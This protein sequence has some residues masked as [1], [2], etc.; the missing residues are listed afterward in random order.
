MRLHKLGLSNKAEQLM[1]NM[2]GGGSI[3]ANFGTVEEGSF[4]REHYVCSLVRGDDLLRGQIV[5]DLMLKLAS[6]D[7]SCSRSSAWRR[8]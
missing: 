5:G 2:V 6:R 4:V 7:S 3:M 8:R 1:L